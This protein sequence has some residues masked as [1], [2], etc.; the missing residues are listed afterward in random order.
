MALLMKPM[1]L[2]K[3]HYPL[4]APVSPC[5]QNKHSTSLQLEEDQENFELCRRYVL[6]NIYYHRYLDTNSHEVR[7]QLHGLATKFRVHALPGHADRLETLWKR[8]VETQDWAEHAQVSGGGDL[9][10]GVVL[11]V[12]LMM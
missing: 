1:Y 10:E 3:P 2:C 8:L 9:V 6:S 7:R 4:P 12:S 5:D 11:P